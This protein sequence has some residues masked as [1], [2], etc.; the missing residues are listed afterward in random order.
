MPRNLDEFNALS[1]QQRQW[2]Y[3]KKHSLYEKFQKQNRK[4]W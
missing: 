2:L 4:E 1:L 3:D